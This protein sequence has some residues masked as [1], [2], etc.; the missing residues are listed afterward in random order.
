LK[1]GYQKDS[2][3]GFEQIKRTENEK[4]KEKGNPCELEYMMV[5]QQI[6]DTGRKKDNHKNG[7]GVPEDIIHIA[8]FLCSIYQSL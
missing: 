7:N 1:P 4:G 5:L 3:V 8:F 2:G 6:E